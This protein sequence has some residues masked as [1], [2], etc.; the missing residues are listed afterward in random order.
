MSVTTRICCR[1]TRAFKDTICIFFRF[2][3]VLKAAKG[4]MWNKGFRTNRRIEFPQ[5]IREK[6]NSRCI[7]VYI[8]RSETTKQQTDLSRK[9]EVEGNSPP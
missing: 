7:V 2:V 1:T 5:R 8:P 9:Y 4:L 6:V 3:V